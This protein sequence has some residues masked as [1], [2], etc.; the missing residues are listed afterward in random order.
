MCINV[1]RAAP[2]LGLNG[3]V[4]DVEPHAEHLARGFDSP[5]FHDETRA[6][7]LSEGLFLGLLFHYI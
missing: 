1:D 2:I 5:Q 3:F 6:I 4:D 7:S